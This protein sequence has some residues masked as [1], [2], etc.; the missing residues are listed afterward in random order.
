MYKVLL[1][2]IS[3]P[4]TYQPFILHVFKSKR[5]GKSEDVISGILIPKAR[6]YYYPI[7][8]GIPRLLIGYRN[9]QFEKK[10]QKRIQTIIKNLSFPSTKEYETVNIETF[11]RH[12]SKLHSYQIEGL[13]VWGVKGEQIVK[14]LKRIFHI[15][16]SNLKGKWVLDAG[17]GNGVTSIAFLKTEGQVVAMDITSGVDTCASFCKKKKMKGRERIHFI[18]GSVENPPFRK[19]VFD[20]IYSNGVLHHTSSTKKSFNKL[21]PL[22]RKSGKFYIWLY[23]KN[24]SLYNRTVYTINR[25]L[26]YALTPFGSGGIYIFS[27]VWV[28]LMRLFHNF[29]NFLNRGDS[30]YLNLNMRE[31]RLIIYDQFAIKF[32]WHHTYQ[33]VIKWFRDEKFDAYAIPGIEAPANFQDHGVSIIGTKKR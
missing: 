23:V 7:I 2:I 33:E 10:Y 15:G 16:S 12:W 9:L 3:D 17:C 1:T 13:S 30:F 11:S 22:V 32:D 31:H 18:Q 6:K 27:Y 19:N 24:K 29:R 26:R 8:N 4:K 14:D 28:F 25:M 5:Q 21:T 20:I